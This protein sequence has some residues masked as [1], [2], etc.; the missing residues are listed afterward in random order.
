MHGYL[1]AH[2]GVFDPEEI[3]ILSAAL[4]KAW[5]LIQ[6]SGAK[7]ETDAEAEVMRAIL[8]KHIIETA[9]QGERDERLLCDVALAQLRKSN[10]RST[11][12]GMV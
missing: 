4:D 12:P 3:R 1:R 2:P 11:P 10:L 9:K 7:F 8:A 6:A 5:Q